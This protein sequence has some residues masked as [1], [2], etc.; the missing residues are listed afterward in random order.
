MIA[1]F[2]VLEM[3]LNF[4]TLAQLRQAL[5]YAVTKLWHALPV[6]HHGLQPIPVRL[7][8]RKG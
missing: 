6:P 3:A 7:R 5:Q 4:P 1:M 8:H 2:A